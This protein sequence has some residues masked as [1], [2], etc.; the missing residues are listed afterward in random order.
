MSLFDAPEGALIVHA[1]NCQGVWGSGIA[2]E[3]AKRY[4]KS[5]ET[6]RDICNEAFA[7]DT[8][9]ELLLGWSEILPEQEGEAHRI[10]C[11]F[12]SKDYGRNVDPPIEIV[13]NTVSA[14]CDLFISCTHLGFDRVY[15]NKFNSGFF[16]VPWQ[17]TEA[18]LG[19]LFGSL[20]F[21]WIVC[22]PE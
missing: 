17:Y 16:N 11:L 3:F 2:A 10:G 7:A 8:E 12:T 19:T 18:I 22:D 15:S 6:Y 21:E 14:V 13:V 20:D 5:F 9:P 1:C 4:P